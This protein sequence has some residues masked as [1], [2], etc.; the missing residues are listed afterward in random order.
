M[1]RCCCGSV[2]LGA[3]VIEKHFTLSRSD[4]GVDSAF[5]LEPEELGQLVK[6]TERAW[7]ALGKIKYGV[8]KDENKSIQFRRSLY[9]VKDLQAGDVLSKENVKCIRTGMGLSTKYLDY[10]IGT[11]VKRDVKR[12]TALNWELIK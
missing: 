12:G 5:S 10:L 3:T 9:I 6:E 11:S 8:T 2:A 1:Y 7:Q 4:G